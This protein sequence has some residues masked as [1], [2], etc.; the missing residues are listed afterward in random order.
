M[1]VGCFFFEPLIPL[2]GILSLIIYTYIP[3]KLLNVHPETIQIV[4]ESVQNK[5]IVAEA[6]PVEV[7]QSPAEQSAA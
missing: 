6:A 4:R 2:T 7:M 3:I 1:T 5:D